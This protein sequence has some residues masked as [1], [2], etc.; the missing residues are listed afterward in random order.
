M[1]GPENQSAAIAVLGHLSSPYVR[2]SGATDRCPTRRPNFCL[3]MKESSSWVIWRFAFGSSFSI[4]R[5]R[6]SRRPVA[7][8]QEPWAQ[9]ARSVRAL[10]RSAVASPRRRARHGSLRFRADCQ[11]LTK[12]LYNLCLSFGHDCVCKGMYTYI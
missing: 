11:A 4:S 10:T 5:R 6:R 12:A 9:S 3:S 7:T 2:V 1:S 8:L